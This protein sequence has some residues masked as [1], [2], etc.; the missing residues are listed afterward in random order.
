[1]RLVAVGTGTVVPEKNRGC[2]CFY[3]ES[4]GS[5]ILLDCGSGAVQGLARRSLAWQTLTDLIVTHFH[6]D[7]VGA[8]PG[9]LFALK[10]GMRPTRREPLD[11]W[12]PRGTRRLFAALAEALGE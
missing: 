1:M 10:H 8:I 11:V 6:T 9:L 4:E 12:G 2:T 3:L 7:H 5:R